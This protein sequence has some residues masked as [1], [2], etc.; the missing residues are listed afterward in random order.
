MR[1]RVYEEAQDAKKSEG[2]K[3]D[4]EGRC[5]SLSLSLSL[6]EQCKARVNDVNMRGGQAGVTALSQVKSRLTP[7]ITQI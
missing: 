7:L 4:E 6:L 1:A 5:A 3:K 2:E